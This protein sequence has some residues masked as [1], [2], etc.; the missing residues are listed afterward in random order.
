MNGQCRYKYILL[1]SDLSYFAKKHSDS[2]K[3]FHDSVIIIIIMFEFL[4]DNI[5]AVFSERFFFKK[6]SAYL[7]V[8]TMLIF[9]QTGSFIHMRQ[10]SFRGFSR[11]SKRN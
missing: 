2:T 6:Q 7:S 3:T 10:T 1:R 8:Q 5:F 11:K 9:S 4:I